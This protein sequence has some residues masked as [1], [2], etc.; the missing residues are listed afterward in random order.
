MSARAR[1]DA[2]ATTGV[3]VMRYGL[4]VALLVWG[5]AKFTAA[6]AEAIRPLVEHS[7]V[8]SWLYGLFG[9]RGTSALFGIFEVGIGA[10]IAA[11]RWFRRASGYASLAAAV[12]F[13]ITFSFLFTTPD[14]LRL[15][16]PWRDSFTKDIVLLGA[17]LFIAAE[18]L[19]AAGTNDSCVGTVPPSRPAT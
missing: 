4:V 2:L 5:L 7:P 12:M 16:N 8:L 10:L 17:A 13:A 1:T 19:G 9:L 15:A 6:E 11:R 14:M 3:R 18:A